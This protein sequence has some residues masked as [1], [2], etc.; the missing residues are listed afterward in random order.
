MEVACHEGTASGPVYK[1]AKCSGWVFDGL[2]A[3]KPPINGYYARAWLSD[4]LRSKWLA[5]ADGEVPT[6]SPKGAAVPVDDSRATGATGSAGD[7]GVADSQSTG[8][9]GSADDSPHDATGAPD[10]SDHDS[11]PDATGGSGA[12]FAGATGT[13]DDPV[14][15]GPLVSMATGSGGQST[16]NAYHEQ[17]AFRRVRARSPLRQT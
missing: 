5:T 4:E 15:D 16:R 13:A 1:A 3:D 6:M 12:D 7:S 14:E 17:S 11:D 10:D 8:S 9:A 2:R